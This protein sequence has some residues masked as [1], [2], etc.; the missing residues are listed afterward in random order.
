MNKREFDQWASQQRRELSDRQR[1]ERA[2]LELQMLRAV[3]DARQNHERIY[4]AQRRETQQKIDAIIG[5]QENAGIFYKAFGGARRDQTQLETC[6]GILTDITDKAERAVLDVRN[7]FSAQQSD[8]STRHSS[9]N[10]ELSRT[11]ER[12][13]Q[14]EKQKSPEWD[15]ER[16][17]TFAALKRARLDERG[18][19]EGVETRDDFSKAHDGQTENKEERERQRRIEEVRERLERSE[20]PRLR[21]T[22][23]YERER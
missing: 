13:R 18:R 14:E 4:G 8:L 9:E 12:R 20:G 11:I 23:G 17:Q 5:R 6:R 7:S 1:Q 16:L 19:E 22:R 15:T 10:I 21:R 3:S 2:A